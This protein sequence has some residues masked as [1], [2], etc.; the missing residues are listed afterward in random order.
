MT[1]NLLSDAV[2]QRRA[3]G[4]RIEDLTGQIDAQQV[5]LVQLKADLDTLTAARDGLAMTIKAEA[6]KL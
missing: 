2:E 5:R 1:E 4:Q 6:G 3:L